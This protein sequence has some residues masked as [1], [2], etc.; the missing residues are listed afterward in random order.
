MA[1]EKIGINIKSNAKGIEQQL[2][3]FYSK[4][5][6]LKIDKSNFQ[7]N[8]E[9]IE[10]VL[11]QVKSFSVISDTAKSIQKGAGALE[12]IS[13]KVPEMT[14]GG[15]GVLVT[16]MDAVSEIVQLLGSTAEAM[17]QINNKVPSNLG[18]LLPKL[19]NM[20]VAITGMGILVGIVGKLAGKSSGTASAGLETV[21]G[22]TKLL[23]EA[24]EALKQIDD[25]VPSNLENLAPK[26]LNMGIAIAGMGILVGIAGK[27]ADKNPVAALVGLGSIWA[28]T[29]LLMKAAEALKQINDKVPGNLEKVTAKMVSIGIAIGGMGIIVAAV[30]ALVATGVGALIAGAGLA[31]VYLLASELMHVSEAISQL[32]KKV[33][34]NID[35]V[36]QKIKVIAEVIKEF[37]SLG[38]PITL[39]KNIFGSLNTKVVSRT[40]KVFIDIAKDFELLNKMKIQSEVI[41]KK[42]QNIQEVL[43]MIKGS[44]ITEMLGSVLKSA[45]SSALSGTVDSFVAIALDFDVLQGIPINAEAVSQKLR[46][47]QE[48]LTVFDGVGLREIFDSFTEAINTSILSGIVTQM[49]DIA[50]SLSTLQGIPLD[51]EAIK[52]KIESIKEVLGVFKGASL[53]DLFGH[54]LEA[55]D[56]TVL[57]MLIDQLKSVTTKLKEF[58]AEA[59]DET[60]LASI[61]QKI[62]N[63]KSVLALFT[64]AS[65]GELLD[66][67]YEWASTKIVTGTIGS[68]ITVCSKFKELNEVTEGLNFE[69][70]GETIRKI[71][72]VLGELSGSTLEDL[73]D[74]VIEASDLKIAATSIEKVVEI[75]ENLSQLQKL[76]FTYSSIEKKI[77]DVQKAIELLDSDKGI[78][79]GL[80][81]IFNG[82]IDESTLKTAAASMQQVVA[83]A[84]NL[85]ILQ[86]IPLD[87][88]R[89]SEKIGYV[90]AAIEKMGKA[91]LLDLF[92][93]MLKTTE[94]TEVKN[95]VDAMIPL[96]ESLNSLVKDE[97]NDVMI[98]DRISKLNFIIQN[99]GSGSL[100]TIFEKMLKVEELSQIKAAVDILIQ[101]ISS[102]GN[103]NTTAE[104]VDF[105]AVNTTIANVANSVGQIN[106]LESATDGVNQINALLQSFNMLI[107]ML[108]GL[109]GQFLP[110]GTSYGQQILQGFNG[111]A[112]PTKILEQINQLITN[113]QAKYS[114]FTE[115]G[116][117]YGNNLKTGFAEG[118]ANMISLL[119]DA[120]NKLT[121]EESKAQFSI[122]LNTL[123]N[124]LGA[125]LID[126]FKEGIRGMAT[127]INEELSNVKTA[128][129][130]SQGGEVE[131]HASGGLAGIFK[132]KGTDT[133]P[134]MLTPGEF[135]QRRAAVSTFGLDFMNKVNNLDV[136]GAFSALTGRFNTQS[137]LI[138][139]VST[140]VNNI[141][142]TTNNANRVTQNVV[143]GNADYIMK[144]AS[145]YL[146]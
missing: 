11:N 76:K 25:K 84:K 42:I 108:Q 73:L 120:I 66:D 71:K 33:P 26:L 130:K 1:I 104:N 107:T 3:Q 135:V 51:T 43:D 87:G 96:M 94:L 110:I 69:T 50:N 32:D 95:S 54:G 36:K 53:K 129:T 124:T 90:N 99:L 92:G 13:D 7:P 91:N 8:V 109:E 77:T 88:D 144:R 49:V 64:G 141:N 139:A 10:K 82:K 102:F 27:L 138:P 137:M 5:K 35:K 16:G 41:K 4:V 93:Q 55:I 143:G 145:R 100:K 21:G 121:T 122:P 24:A 70:I 31:T 136:R 15:S 133:V 52:I 6:Q 80:M 74:S 48:A 34:T 12:S 45:D 29:E 114:T 58:D 68:L 105:Q 101:I 115:I 40:I 106:N 30:G 38:S 103:L 98:N 146:R 65:F 67:L 44:S 63:I 57:I 9:K 39:I 119:T 75:A 123:G 72:E 140:V 81:G 128:T 20:G 62:Q 132:K 61:S 47:I 142:H 17:E 85:A 83:I 97:F 127:A 111:V 28:I 134:A 126:G 113:L 59:L 78:F 56:T 23:G 118:V 86:E 116:K 89:V 60:A 37:S 131:F 22:I 2:S 117:T 112:V 19:L 18:K 79:A 125:S 46:S 14:G